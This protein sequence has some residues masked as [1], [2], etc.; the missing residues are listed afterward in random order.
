MDADLSP[1]PPLPSSHSL[2]A[3]P[4]QIDS[5]HYIRLLLDRLIED[6]VL[7]NLQL[8]TSQVPAISTLLGVNVEERTFDL[9]APFR[10]GQSEFILTAKGQ[11]L[12]ITAKLKGTTVSFRSELQ[13]VVDDQGMILYRCHFPQQVNYSQQRHNFRVETKD[14]EINARL[15]TST[16]KSF[17]ARLIDISKGGMRVY[18]HNKIASKLKIRLML[19]CDINFDSDGEQER[20]RVAVRNI[21]PPTEEGEEMAIVGFKFI[22]IDARQE[23]QLTH[24]IAKIERQ[25]LREQNHPG[26]EEGGRAGVVMQKG[27]G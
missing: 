15:Y 27:E 10:I 19:S 4:E 20:V 11:P 16:G 21:L 22:E 13:S 12:A 14:L 1:S 25:L 6:R 3:A 24:R 17:Q 23:L 2:H 7:F 5:F 26:E 9:D 8:G 18:I